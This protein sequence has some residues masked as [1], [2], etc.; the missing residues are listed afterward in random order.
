MRKSKFGVHLYL[1]SWLLR[2]VLRMK[3][4]DIAVRL[5]C[6]L[7]QANRMYHLQNSRMPKWIGGER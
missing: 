1:K 7:S 6:S 5:D 4:K 2:R 3:F